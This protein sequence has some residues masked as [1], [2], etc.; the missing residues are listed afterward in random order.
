M[1]GLPSIIFFLICEEKL[2]FPPWLMLNYWYLYFNFFPYHQTFF[3]PIFMFNIKKRQLD[4]SL[5]FGKCSKISFVVP[6]IWKNHF[7]FRIEFK[8]N[9]V[10]GLACDWLDAKWCNFIKP[11]CRLKQVTCDSTTELERNENVACQSV[12]VFTH[13]FHWPSYFDCLHVTDRMEWTTCRGTRANEVNFKMFIECF[14]KNEY[15]NIYV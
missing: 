4:P 6:N 3:P 14:G 11:A 10:F 8:D 2:F 12:W 15:I 13:H 7:Q 5:Q 9:V 1:S